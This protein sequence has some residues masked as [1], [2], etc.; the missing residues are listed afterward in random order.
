[1]GA[2]AVLDRIAQLEPRVLF[3]DAGALYKGKIH[4]LT[5]KLAEI[6]TGLGNLGAVVVF[7]SFAQWIDLQKVMPGGQSDCDVCFYEDFLKQAADQDAPLE[8]LQLPPDTPVYVLF[9]SGTTGSCHPPL[10]LLAST[11]G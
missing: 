4:D 6:T 7:N 2:T 9:S 8:F 3:A 10:S 1:M 11:R 5:Q